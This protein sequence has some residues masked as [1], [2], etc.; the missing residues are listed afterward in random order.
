MKLI[1][2]FVSC[3]LAVTLSIMAAMIATGTVPF[4]PV[5]VIEDVDADS[6]VVKVEG[7]Q[8][9]VSIFSGQAGIVDQLVAELKAQ[10][11]KNK[12]TEEVLQADRIEFE[13]KMAQ[14][15]VLEQTLS[16]LRDEVAKKIVQISDNEEGNF[17]KLAE[18]YG[19]MD[20]E[21]ASQLLQKAESD[22]AAK[23]I[24]LIGDR[25]AAAIMGAAVALGDGGTKTAAEWT[26]AMR[27]M[28]NQKKAK[29]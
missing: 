4:Q 11:Q 14:M 7:E 10:I 24:S 27:R 26:D 13:Q 3:L 2:I 6:L 18:M 20:P 19:K 9:R 17:K 8:K 15:R 21:S 22:R 1:F 23:I 16:E 28:N 12:K 29:L 25:Q 5:E